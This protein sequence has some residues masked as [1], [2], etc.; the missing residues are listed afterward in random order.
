MKPHVLS[1]QAS[2]FEDVALDG[3]TASALLVWLVFSFPSAFTINL[4]QSHSVQ[5]QE[6]RLVSQWGT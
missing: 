6:R 3:L 1:A 5:V 4:R 2:S